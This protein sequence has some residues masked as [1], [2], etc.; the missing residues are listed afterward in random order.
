VEEG[1]MR[2][3]GFYLLGPG[4]GGRWPR[5]GQTTRLGTLVPEVKAVIESMFTEKFFAA[6]EN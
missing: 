5:P 2:A 3:T 6:A 4:S 1:E